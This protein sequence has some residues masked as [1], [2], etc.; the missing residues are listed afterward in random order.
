MFDLADGKL[1][2]CLLAATLLELKIIPSMEMTPR[3]SGEIQIIIQ[4]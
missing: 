4:V 2:S 3:P 1:E